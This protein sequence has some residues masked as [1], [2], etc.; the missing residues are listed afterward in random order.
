MEMT[1]WSLVGDGKWKVLS[2]VK[3]H[4]AVTRGRMSTMYGRRPDDAPLT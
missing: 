1:R 4:V 2:T 3:L